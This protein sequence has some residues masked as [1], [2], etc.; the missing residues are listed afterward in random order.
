M[1]K[2]APNTKT[3]HRIYLGSASSSDGIQMPSIQICYTVSGSES[4]EMESATQL[5][6]FFEQSNTLHLNALRLGP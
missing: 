6:H 3:L 2:A 4:R 1:K 5:V